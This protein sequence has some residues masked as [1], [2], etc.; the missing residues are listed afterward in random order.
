MALILLSIATASRW[1]KW[2]TGWEPEADQVPGEGPV[3]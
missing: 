2:P 3:P 1:R